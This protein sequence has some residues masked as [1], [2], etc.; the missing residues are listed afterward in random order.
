[1]QVPIDRLYRTLGLARP[2][3]D[4][5]MRTSQ[6]LNTDESERV[7]ALARLIGQAQNIVEESGRAQEFDAALWI[8]G[9]L[10][11]PLPALDG[12]TPEEFVDTA[13]GQQ[14]MSDLLAQQQP[15]AYA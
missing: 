11:R 12:R 1:M 7:L 10:N 3:I 2:T 9:W 6:P 4:R 8:A 13:E 15:G 5:K 14:L